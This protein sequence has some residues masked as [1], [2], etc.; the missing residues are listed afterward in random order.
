MREIFDAL[1]VDQ[2]VVVKH[3]LDGKTK[4][5]TAEFLGLEPA[6]IT[7]HFTE[8]KQRVARAVPHL[9]G[10]VLIRKAK[11]AA[12]RDKPTPR[13]CVDCGTKVARRSTRCR[14]C[15]CKLVLAPLAAEARRKKKN[16]L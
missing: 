16:M 4:R 2:L 6:T 3:C 5:E 9:M 15:N 7:Y 10:D 8:A 12:R 13:Y 14:P 11:P 1:T